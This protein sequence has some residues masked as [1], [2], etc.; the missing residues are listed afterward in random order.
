MSTV[1]Y[2]KGKHKFNNNN[3]CKSANNP[4][5]GRLTKSKMYCCAN[6]GV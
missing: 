5:C 3:Y 4:E 1:G 2:N 6:L